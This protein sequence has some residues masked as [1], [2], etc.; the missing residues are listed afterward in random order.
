MAR[1]AAVGFHYCQ[2]RNSHTIRFPRQPPT[3]LD[4]DYYG[5]DKVVL[6]LLEYLR[7]RPA[8]RLD[9]TCAGG[10]AGKGAGSYTQN[11]R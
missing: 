7:R 5:L 6:R 10:R 2:L 8:A 4:S 1:F 3:K 9:R 11:R